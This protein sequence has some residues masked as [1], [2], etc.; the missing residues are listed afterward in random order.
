MTR[1]RPVLTP[2]AY[3]VAGSITG[4]VTYL[5]V[6]PFTCRPSGACEGWI[7]FQYQ[8]N[9]AGHFQAAS[10]GLLL[11]ACLSALLWLALAPPS[12]TFAM[13]RLVA[14]PI[15]IAGAAVSIYSQSVLLVLG[16]VLS[17]VMLWL[18]WSKPRE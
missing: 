5:L 16:P 6:A 3:L 15:F 18:M 4:V 1:S 12:R 8:P 9:S 13:A 2:V 10:A 14:T 7:A 17:V 11:G